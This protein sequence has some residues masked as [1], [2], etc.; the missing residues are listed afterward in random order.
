MGQ[1]LDLDSSIK[2]KSSNS[3][4]ATNDLSK[5]IFHDVPMW[6]FSLDSQKYGTV[7]AVHSVHFPLFDVVFTSFFPHCRYISHSSFHSSFKVQVSTWRIIWTPPPR[8]TDT[9]STLPALIVY[10]ISLCLLW[11]LSC[12]LL[13]CINH[14]IFPCIFLI[15]SLRRWTYKR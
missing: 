2:K 12:D 9:S 3:T 5:F 13:H 4:D 11:S 15:Y 10:I 1:T 14:N 6:I 8:D 7:S